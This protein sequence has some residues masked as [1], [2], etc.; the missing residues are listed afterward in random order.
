MEKTIYIVE[1]EN[2]GNM[3][4]FWSKE[5][6]TNCIIH[7]YLD[8]DFGGVKNAIMEELHREEPDIDEIEGM[9]NYIK[10]DLQNIFEHGYADGFMFMRE[11][12]IE[13]EE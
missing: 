6:A 5:K 13:V 9:L 12:E 3:R 8:S 11:V 10:E 4:G 2:N 1:D 7:N